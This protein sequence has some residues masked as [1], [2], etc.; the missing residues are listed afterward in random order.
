MKITNWR[1]KLAATLVAG[2]MISP[3]AAQ[4]ANLD[5]NLVLNPGFESVDLGTLGSYNAPKVNN[6]MGTGFTYS[7]QPGVT[8]VPDYADGADPPGAG[9]WYFSANNQPGS[10]TGDVRAPDVVFQDIAV[11]SGAT[12][13][14]IASGEAAVRLSAYMSSYLNDNDFGIVHLQFK[15]AGGTTI[16]TLQIADSDPGPNNVWS[17][18]SAFTSIPAATTSI[19][20]SLFGGVRNGGTDGYIDNVDVQVTNA[21]NVLLFAQVNT[22]TGHVSIRNLTGQ[23]VPIDYYEITSASGALVRANWSSLQDQN[24]PGFPAGNG[25]GSGWEEGG[26]GG[27]FGLSESNLVGNSLVANGANIGLG[28][29]FNTAG[30]HDLAFSYAV[31]SPQALDADF[32]GDGDADGQD[33]LIWQRGVGVGTTKAQGNADGDAD[34]DAAD[35]AIWKGE[36]GQS[37]FGGPSTIVQGFVRYVT[38]TAAVPEPGTIVLAGLGAGV[39][40]LSRRR[41]PA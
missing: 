16:G 33:F 32:D 15:N 39:V 27:N 17:L 31:L 9:N 29:A 20:A 19:R 41:R 34:V 13:T 38:A 5:A 25:S 30:A 24:L 1:R 36:F 18:N 10:P 23:P 28:P 6:W 12:G 7:H 3:A 35:L 14:Q 40:M 26:G 21:A 11:N 8:G 37:A 22:T 4:A 2:G